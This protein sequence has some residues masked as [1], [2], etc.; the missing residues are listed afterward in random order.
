MRHKRGVI[1]VG[2]TNTDLDTIKTRSHF[3]MVDHY[4][5]NDWNFKSTSLGLSSYSLVGVATANPNATAGTDNDDLFGMAFSSDGKRLYT[6]SYGY[7]R[8][9]DLSL[10]FDVHNMTSVG[11][12]K[13]YLDSTNNT[14]PYGIDV[15]TNGEWMFLGKWGGN[16]IIKYKLNEPFEF[17]DKLAGE[18]EFSSGSNQSFVV[19]DGVTQISAVVVGAGGGGSYT[20]TSSYPGGGGGGGGLSYGTFAVTPGETLTVNVGS[21]G[22]GGTFGFDSST[23]GKNGGDSQIKRG[24]TILLEG[25]GG[26]G[27]GPTGFQIGTGGP[28]GGSTGTERDGGGDGGDG[29]TPVSHGYGGGGGG[30]AGYSGDGGNGGGYSAGQSGSGGGGG[31]GGGDGSGASS[32]NGGGVGVLGEGDSGSGGSSGNFAIAGGNGSGG[33]GGEFGG[34]GAGAHG[35]PTGQYGTWPSA[36][37]QSGKNGRARIVYGTGRSYPIADNVGELATNVEPYG[38]LIAKYDYETGHSST[39][40][41]QGAPKGLRFKP[42]GTKMYLVGST[43]DSVAE[44]TLSTAWDP[45]T[46]TL[47]NIFDTSAKVSNCVAI[48]FKPDGT[49][50]YVMC[51]STDKIYRY[52]LSTA[53]DV[54]SASFNSEWLIAYGNNPP[55]GFKWHSDGTKFWLLGNTV[56]LY[57]Y[58]VSTAWDITSTVSADHTKNI[59]WQDLHGLDWTSDGKQL[60]VVRG[61]GYDEAHVFSSNT[62][63][64]IVDGSN[65]DSLTQIG[66]AVQLYNSRIGQTDVWDVCLSNDPSNPYL[67]TLG[68]DDGK[69]IFRWKLGNT[70]DLK[71][72]DLGFYWSSDSHAITEVEWSPDG[73]H[74]FY[75]RN[76]GY[77]HQVDVTYPYNMNNFLDA[78]TSSLNFSSQ[79]ANPRSFSFRLDPAGKTIVI[80]SNDNDE[81]YTL[82]LHSP[83]NLGSGAYYYLARDITSDVGDEP[84]A[85]AVSHNRGSLLIG[86]RTNN[87]VVEWKLNF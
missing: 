75:T 58:S 79:L 41:K 13:T 28:G 81:V 68:G 16:E 33:S 49:I 45:S 51:S 1:G 83:W 53:W 10:P 47:A 35:G 69:T 12:A 22:Q 11:T 72:W 59:N 67:F 39:N 34:G 44:F 27:G 40:G 32:A 76:G 61:D 71:S 9:H 84:R 2:N 19:P 86:E 25:E 21:G 30:A 26:T 62:A 43:Y 17:Y 5:Y 4:E 18:S 20:Q 29:N 6:Q 74:M 52:D 38:G 56:W 23:K 15:S 77:I 31:G 8:I 36:N 42:D 24:S 46:G 57:Q 64:N 78:T 66:N 82:T 37:G 48:D 87:E 7:V 60:V 85:L 50:M 73:M 55:R 63:W 70:T 14:T 3:G 54:S 65:N 80:M